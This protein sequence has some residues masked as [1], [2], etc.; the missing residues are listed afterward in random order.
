MSLTHGLDLTACGVVCVQ[1]WSESTEYRVSTYDS[2]GT[3]LLDVKVTT[4]ANINNPVFCGA[5]RLALCAAR[6][7]ALLPSMWHA[8]PRVIAPCMVWNGEG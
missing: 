2:S 5:V 4:G 3:K 7:F 8:E 1:L 6:P